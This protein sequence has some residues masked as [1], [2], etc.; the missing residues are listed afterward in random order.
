MRKQVFFTHVT[1]TQKQES[2]DFQGKRNSSVV[3]L[4][5]VCVSVFM[6]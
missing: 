6:R 5:C 1:Q 2:R 4:S 3:E